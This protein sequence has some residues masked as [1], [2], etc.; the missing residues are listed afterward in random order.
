MLSDL[1]GSSHALSWPGHT[2]SVEGSKIL[3]GTTWERE[4]CAGFILLIVCIRLYPMAGGF[5]PSVLQFQD[6]PCRSLQPD[7]LQK[8]TRESL[9]PRFALAGD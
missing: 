7:S 2:N 1:G 3:F 4:N 5:V 9:S 8:G 6:A